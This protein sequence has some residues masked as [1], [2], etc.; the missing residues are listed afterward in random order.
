MLSFHK[1]GH[2]TFTASLSPF[3]ALTPDS[4]ASLLLQ[5]GPFKGAHKWNY[6]V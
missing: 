5:S 2:V 6:G 4:R 3:P 1:D